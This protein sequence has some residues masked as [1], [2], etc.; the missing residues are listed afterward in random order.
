MSDL[1]DPTPNFVDVETIEMY[2]NLGEFEHQIINYDELSAYT[3]SELR[4]E[5][6]DIKHVLRLTEP[7]NEDLDLVEKEEEICEMQNG[8]SR[9]EYCFNTTVFEPLDGEDF[10]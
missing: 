6:Q 1:Y 4:E 3:K 8:S 5:I 10:F 9:N 7:Q 2:Q